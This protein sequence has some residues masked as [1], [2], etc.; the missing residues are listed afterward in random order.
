MRFFFVGCLLLAGC[1]EFILVK[2]EYHPSDGG[3]DI[4]T[5]VLPGGSEPD[6]IVEVPNE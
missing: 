4:V 3:P 5:K 1:Q 6:V 2:I